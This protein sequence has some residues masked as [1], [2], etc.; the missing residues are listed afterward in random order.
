MDMKQNMA[1]L[2]KN[3]LKPTKLQDKSVS[4]LQI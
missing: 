2:I 1:V 3:A 4:F